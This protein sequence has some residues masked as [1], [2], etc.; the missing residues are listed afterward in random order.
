MGLSRP[1]QCAAD[2][3]GIA[4]PPLSVPCQRWIFLRHPIGRCAFRSPLLVGGTDTERQRRAKLSTS[5]PARSS[6]TRLSLSRSAWRAGLGDLRGRLPN[7]I[8]AL[9]ASSLSVSIAK[10]GC[11]THCRSPLQFLL[12]CWQ[13]GSAGA[14]LTGL[15]HEECGWPRV[16]GLS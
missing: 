5:R 1:V 16:R 6:G 12:T 13:D 7:L 9:F 15:R 8:E 14:F 4:K 2:D 10:Q 11:L 3:R